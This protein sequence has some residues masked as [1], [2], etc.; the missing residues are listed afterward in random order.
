MV[1]FLSRNVS[2]CLLLTERAALEGEY[3]FILVFPDMLLTFYQGYTEI[4][5]Y[6]MNRVQIHDDH[7]SENRLHRTKNTGLTEADKVKERLANLQKANKTD[8]LSFQVQLWIYPPGGGAPKKVILFFV[9]FVASVSSDSNQA[10]IPSFRETADCKDSAD[11]VMDTILRKVKLAYD[12]CPA[13]SAKQS[14]PS[15]FSRRVALFF[16]FSS[17]TDGLCN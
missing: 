14:Y 10:Q 13:Y 12:K 4:V 16:R 7:A 11:Q 17:Y 9:F 1:F 15:L 3:R 8:Q 6:L 5:T 2:C